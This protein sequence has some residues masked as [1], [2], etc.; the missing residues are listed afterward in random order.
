MPTLLGLNRAL[1]D[2]KGNGASRV[3]HMGSRRG[4]GAPS[5]DGF[6]VF[7][8][9][10]GFSTSP[11]GPLPDRE[12]ARLIAIVLHHSYPEIIYCRIEQH[13]ADARPVTIEEYHKKPRR[14]RRR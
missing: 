6:Y 9:R 7:F 8:E 11:C 10:P 14:K 13:A 4:A 2:I 12:T 5:T 1:A 3:L